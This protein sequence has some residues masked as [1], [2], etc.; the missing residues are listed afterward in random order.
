MKATRDVTRLPVRV[1]RRAI[2]CDL[3]DNEATHVYIVDGELARGELP[4]RG[5]LC[6]GH[7]G[8]AEFYGVSAKIIGG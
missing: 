8:N 7:V 3:C 2:S 1:G 4:H 6:P 5:W